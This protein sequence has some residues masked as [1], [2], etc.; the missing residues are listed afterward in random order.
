MHILPYLSTLVTFA[1]TAAVFNRYRQRGGI[2]LLFWAIGLFLYGLGTLSEVVLSLTYNAFVLKLWYLTGAMLTAAWLGTGT[3]H[4][5]IRKG[6]TAQILTG[7]LA[8]VS[9]LALVLV[10][11]APVNSA[12]YE[13]TRPVSEQYKDSP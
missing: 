1:F 13:V 7:I 3:L 12:A 8:A 2:Y 4:L 6:N 5:L 11:A 9:V 10:F